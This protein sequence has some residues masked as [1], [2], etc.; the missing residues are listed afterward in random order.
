ML[1]LGLHA[2]EGEAGSLQTLSGQQ[3]GTGA[4]EVEEEAIKRVVV[5][6]SKH[7]ARAGL[8]R[9]TVEEFAFGLAHL[10]GAAEGLL[11]VDLIVEIQTAAL[12]GA[13]QVIPEH[14]SSPKE[15]PWGV[16]TVEA[17]FI[18]RLPSVP[19]IRLK[20]WLALAH[21]IHKRTLLGMT[22]SPPLSSE[23]T[24]A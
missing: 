23:E 13:V 20:T 4:L 21:F 18:E 16:K 1:V 7:H 3:V 15:L 14:L 6:L 11:A 9:A 22:Y 24:E 17:M 2:E 12:D 10:I 5:R 8:H 19:G